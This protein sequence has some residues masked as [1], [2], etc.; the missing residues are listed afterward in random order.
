MKYKYTELKC[1]KRILFINNR[2]VK[3]TEKQDKKKIFFNLNVFI[4]IGG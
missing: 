1:M 4:L 2:K 3:D